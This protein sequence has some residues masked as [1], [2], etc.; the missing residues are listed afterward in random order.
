MKLEEPEMLDQLIK[1]SQEL[2]E[3]NWDDD[4]KKKLSLSQ[5][6]R[7]QIRNI[8]DMAQA[9]DSFRALEIFIRYQAGRK[10]ISHEFAEDLIEEL[11]K[12]QKESGIETVR[13]YLGYMYR[14]FV[15]KGSL[16]GGA[17]D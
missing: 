10:T 1:N 15:W 9:T 3:R 4:P 12:I 8:L 17:N 16:K 13:L 6:A 7:N 5:L 11:E 2:V 14:Y